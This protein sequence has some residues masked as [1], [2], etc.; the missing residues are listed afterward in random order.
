MT[1]VNV[2]G[3]TTIDSNICTLTVKKS[4]FTRTDPVL[5]SSSIVILSKC[6]MLF[7]LL[8]KYIEFSKK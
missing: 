6:A 2:V 8:S 4:S 3:T 7:Y 1:A 5:P